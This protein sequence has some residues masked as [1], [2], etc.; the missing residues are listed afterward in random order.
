MAWT[1][2]SSDAPLLRELGEHRIDRR[3]V[4]D[5]AGQDAVEPTDSASGSH[6]AAERLALVGEGERRALRGERARDAPGDRVIVGDPHDQ[7]ALALHQLRHGAPIHRSA[8]LLAKDGMN[9]QA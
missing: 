2:K 7:P 8:F 4:L 6:A 3:D 1:R 9:F 5:V